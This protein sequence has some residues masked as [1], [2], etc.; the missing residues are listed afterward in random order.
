MARLWVL[1]TEMYGHKWVSTHGESD[2]G[3]WGK[4]LYDVNGQQ[5]AQGMQACAC[6]VGENAAWPPSAPEFREMCLAATSSLG[7]PTADRAW[8]EACEASVDPTVWKFSHPIVQ[9][10]GRKTDWYAIRHGIPKA[11]SVQNRFN[12]HYA[13]LTAKLQRGEQLVDQQYLLGSDL[14][15]GA[16]AVADALAERKLNELMRCQGVK[17]TTP[18]EALQELRAKMGIKRGEA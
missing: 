4:V 15:N 3:T 8:S 17:K 1:M 14:S 18:Q 6:R 12:K 16:V 9:E 2:S 7:I 10:A 11:I 13:D 5:I